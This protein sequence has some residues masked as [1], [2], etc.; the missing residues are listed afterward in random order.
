MAE[1]IPTLK[2]RRDALGWTIADL[3]R[4]SSTSDLTVQG[5]EVGGGATPDVVARI[6]SALDA[7]DTARK[8]APTPA[9]A[10]TAK[11]E[12]TRASGA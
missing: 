7:E 1:Q 9:K 5:L 8:P 3:A 11:P 6:L 4:H 12:A 2:A 10:P